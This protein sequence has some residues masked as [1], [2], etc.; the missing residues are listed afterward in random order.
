MHALMFSIE[1]FLEK[2]RIWMEIMASNIQLL[3]NK[4][5]WSVLNIINFKLLLI[6]LAEFWRYSGCDSSLKQ[7]PQF[8]A[9]VLGYIHE[10]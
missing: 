8:V 6:H 7:W 10:K 2:K 9:A 4:P 1:D 5:S 3:S